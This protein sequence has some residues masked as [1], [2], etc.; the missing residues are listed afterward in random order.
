MMPLV[1]FY[2]IALINLH[3]GHENILEISMHI[4]HCMFY[5]FQLG[6]NVNAAARHICGA[7]GIGAVAD[8]TRRD[9]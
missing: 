2:E 9:S 3:I 1:P 4:H 6:N 8:R 7:L 5:E